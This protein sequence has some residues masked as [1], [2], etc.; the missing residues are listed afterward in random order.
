MFKFKKKSMLVLILLITSLFVVGC[1]DSKGKKIDK[2][3]EEASSLI[4]NNKLDE[5]ISKYDEIL[6]ID[7]DPNILMNKM[8]LNSTNILTMEILTIR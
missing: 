3:K 5:A 8:R 4:S 6:A 2:L 7:N 1:L